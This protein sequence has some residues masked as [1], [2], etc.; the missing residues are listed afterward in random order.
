MSRCQ[1][2]LE[3]A[4]IRFRPLR[5]EKTRTS[6]LVNYPYGR[7]CRCRRDVQPNA[8]GPAV[9]RPDQPTRLT[10]RPRKLHPSGRYRMLQTLGDDY[11]CLLRAA[12]AGIYPGFA[13]LFN[14][15]LISRRVP[16]ALGYVLADLFIWGD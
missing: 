13:A 6:L 7:S 14:G 15:V 3:P 11:R 9:I 12:P 16:A 10:W 5:V 2:G 4:S 1:A 8:A